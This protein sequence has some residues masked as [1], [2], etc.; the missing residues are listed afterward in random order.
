MTTNP[1][2]LLTFRLPSTNRLIAWAEFGAPTGRPLIFLHGTPSCRLEGADFHKELHKRNIRL[3][4]PDRPGM[5]RSEFHP[6]RT[7]SGYAHDI[8]AL[9]E[10][11]KLTKYAL[12]GGS[13]GGPYALA[14]ARNISPDEGLR[15]VSVLAGMGPVEA[16][17][18]DVNWNTKLT[19]QLSKWTPGLLKWLSYYSLPA[20]KTVP[21][22]PIEEIQVDPVKEAQM[23]KLLDASIKRLK[24][25]DREAMEKP[26]TK[27]CLA[28]TM[29]ES[30]VQGL[31]GYM[32]EAGLYWKEWDFKLEDI[33]FASEGGRPLVLWY[34]TEDINTTIHM[35]RYIAERVPGAD[36][37]E[38]E[39]KTHF[40][41]GIKFV[42]YID[43]LLKLGEI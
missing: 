43:E 38:Q 17:L 42:D 4:A 1:Q 5:G 23:F 31:D 37:R 29:V 2:K 19:L 26:E 30:V 27:E 14:C 40:T 35:G 6:D 25:A 7:I 10:H 20:P 12:M 15:A 24:G 16:G 28:A 9:V 32:Y 34:G 39:G 8:R 21:T 18:K 41:V 11:L 22:G 36:L 13:G 33:K 3:I